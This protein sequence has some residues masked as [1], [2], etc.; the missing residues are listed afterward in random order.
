MKTANKERNNAIT[1]A[2]EYGVVIRC[3]LLSSDDVLKIISLKARILFIGKT[4]CA[5]DS[6]AL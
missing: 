5:L 3:P 2:N 6:D 4:K 1:K